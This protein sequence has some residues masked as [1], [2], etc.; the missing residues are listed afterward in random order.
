MA[1][2][3]KPTYPKSDVKSGQES[4]AY[5]TNVLDGIPPKKSVEQIEVA[6]RP[7]DVAGAN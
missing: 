3:V 2:N 7:K 4:N 5:A 1:D 6:N